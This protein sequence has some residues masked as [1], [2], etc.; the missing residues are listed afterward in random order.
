MRMM[1][2]R[3]FLSIGVVLGEIAFLIDI[4]CFYLELWG[5]HGSSDRVELL[6]IKASF[7]LGI[8]A[9]AMVVLGKRDALERAHYSR[10]WIRS[11][12]LLRWAV[13]FYWSLQ[14]I[15]G[16]VAVVVVAYMVRS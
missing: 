1:L 2:K 7:Y 13:M 4:L 10:L 12:L 9:L 15:M 6:G 14:L 16:I 8:P 5:P 11:V 3:D